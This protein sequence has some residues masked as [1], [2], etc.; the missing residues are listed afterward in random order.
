[1]IVP[2]YRLMQ[3]LLPYRIVNRLT[4]DG[5]RAYNWLRYGDA[6]FPRA[7]AI[8]VTTHCNRRCSYCPQSVDATAVSFIKPAMLVTICDRLAELK[9]RGPV[10]FHF[11]NEPLL[12]RGLE[13]KIG[14]LKSI[15]PK[16]L[17]RVLTNGDMLNDDRAKSLMNCGVFAILVS[18]HE[19]CTERWKERMAALAAKYPTVV[20]V[21]D[22]SQLELSNR[23]GM[24]NAGPKTE[25]AR[26]R[27]DGCRAPS[28]CMHISID[29]DYV[30]CCCDYNK[31]NLLGN[32][33]KLS[34]RQAWR[35]EPWK[36]LRQ[37]VSDGVPV[38]DVC[39][40]CFEAK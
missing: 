7:F 20:H 23:G 26:I 19:G 1:M 35:A 8:E 10:D 22:V 31:V 15:V 12:D 33:A 24:V 3:K 21:T 13:H 29:G 5:Q 37:R 36:T 17:P 2:A 11:F 14:V 34:I 9:W 40:K 30:W 38:L 25:V 16:C 4:T 18:Q 28:R 6:T 32:V 39:K 27:R